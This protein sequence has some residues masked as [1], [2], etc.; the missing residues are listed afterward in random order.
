ILA[1]VLMAATS[2]PPP[3]SLIPSAATRSPAMAGFRNSCFCPRVP[4]SSSTGSVMSLCTM[5]AVLTP[6]LSDHD[7]PSM[8]AVVAHQSSPLPPQSGSRRMPNSPKSA[9]FLNNSR[10]NS[11]ASSHSAACGVI[12]ACTKRFTVSRIM[13]CSSVKPGKLAFLSST[14]TWLIVES[15]RGHILTSA[16]SALGSTMPRTILSRPGSSVSVPEQ[17]ER[18]L[19]YNY[20]FPKNTEVFL[21]IPSLAVLAAAGLAAVPALF[22]ADWKPVT[23]AELAQSAPKVEKDAD[24]EALFWEVHVLDEAQSGQYP[25]SVFTHYVRIKIFTDRG[26]EKF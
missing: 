18:R 25:H 5:N 26:K 2:E 16:G 22:A 24:A 11:P 19:G 1:R 4:S 8:Y 6:P 21:R 3:G 20:Q 17:E 12:S 7:I 23:P 15:P 13:S 14:P 9:P 10:G